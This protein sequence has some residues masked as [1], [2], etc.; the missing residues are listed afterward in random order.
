MV[1]LNYLQGYKL[2]EIAYMNNISSQ[3]VGVYVKKYKLSGLG[4]L[5]MSKGSG[6]PHHLTR[7]QKSEM[8]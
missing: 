5:V 1:I 3:T 2:R 7:E 6:A 8:S 4:G